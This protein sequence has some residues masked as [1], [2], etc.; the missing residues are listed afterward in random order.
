MYTRTRIYILLPGYNFIYEQVYSMTK[1][2]NILLDN[3]ASGIRSFAGNKLIYCTCA[4]NI[5]H[6]N[7]AKIDMH[8]LHSAH[9]TAQCQS[10]SFF[11]HESKLLGKQ[12]K[13]LIYILII[14]FS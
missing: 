2:E 14:M 9:C 7:E 11:L 3:F 10:L 13:E 8:R 12:L 5:F 6:K 1:A 4:I